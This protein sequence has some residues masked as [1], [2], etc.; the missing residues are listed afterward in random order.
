MLGRLPQFREWRPP[1]RTAVG[2]LPGNREPLLSIA[3]VALAVGYAAI[4]LLAVGHAGAP[5]WLSF[6]S[7]LGSLTMFAA[8]SFAIG[9]LAG[10]V[11]GIPRVADARDAQAGGVG[12]GGANR[13]ANASVA[14]NSNLGQVSDWLVK[15]LIGAGL[16]QIA[17]IG[18]TLREIASVGTDNT[19]ILA[20]VVP[21]L[22]VYFVVLGFLGIYIW[23]TTHFAGMVHSAVNTLL[24]EVNAKADQVLHEVAALQSDV[25]HLKKAW[26][27]VETQ[28]NLEGQERD[29]SIK[30][31]VRAFEPLDARDRA[32]IFYHVHRAR[33]N[34]WECNKKRMARTMPIFAALIELD[35]KQQYHRNHAELGYCYK[36]RPQPDYEKALDHLE[37]AIEIRRKQGIDGWTRYEF[38]R[39]LCRIELALQ[40]D[41]AGPDVQDA[42]LEDLESAIESDSIIPSPGCKPIDALR[43]HPRIRHWCQSNAERVQHSSLAEILE[44]G[45]SI[46]ASKP[47]AETTTP[48]LNPAHASRK[49]CVEKRHPNA[50][51][52][53]KP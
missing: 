36:D 7:G 1:E 45:P 33:R 34:N 40:S 21:P 13:A 16:T 10:F 50:G 15:I 19:A 27:L 14:L 31:F 37:K 38:N 42:I 6:W 35:K 25:T 9:G 52:P 5:W 39:A 12:N 18:E 49:R 23:T 2:R 30:E 47:A 24:V 4:L 48:G 53:P 28:L 17:G 22:I 32:M 8:A 41:G 29:R 3:V 44:P 51:A 26:D 43:Q 20:P 11:F 46:S